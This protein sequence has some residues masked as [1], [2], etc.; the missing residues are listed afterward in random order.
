MGSASIEADLGVGRRRD[1]DLGVGRRGDAELG[2]GRRR[3]AELGFDLIKIKIIRVSATDDQYQDTIWT[4]HAW[5]IAHIMSG[6]PNRSRTLG[7]QFFY[8]FG[9]FWQ[10]LWFFDENTVIWRGKKSIL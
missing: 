8:V 2:V 9:S 4:G 5:H 6:T 3:D 10:N 1:A 7:N